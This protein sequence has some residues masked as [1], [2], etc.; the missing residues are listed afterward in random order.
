MRVAL[1]VRAAVVVM[2]GLYDSAGFDN[3]WQ[4][5]A[6]KFW[7]LAYCDAPRCPRTRHGGGGVPARTRLRFPCAY[8]L[9]K[10]SN[11]PV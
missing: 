11:Y 8:Q 5:P 6:A 3:A 1:L 7:H 4:T 2:A 10:L 9:K